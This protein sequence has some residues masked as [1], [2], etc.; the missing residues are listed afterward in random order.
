M[1]VERGQEAP[2]LDP[3]A[4]QRTEL[5]GQLAGAQLALEAVI[6]ELSRNG[7]D[8]AIL[9]ELRN[10][11]VSVIDLRQHVGSANSSDLASLRREVANVTAASHS[12]TQHAVS[13]GSAGVSHPTM[14]HQQARAAIQSVS[15][16]LFDRRVLDPYLQFAS[17]EDEKAYRKREQENAEALKRALALNTPEGD[18]RAVEITRS[19]LADAKAHGADRS[20]DFAQLSG[21]ADAAQAALVAAKPTTELGANSTKIRVADPA[22]AAPTERDISDVASILCA[23]GITNSTNQAQCAGHGLTARST[24][25]AARSASATPG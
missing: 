19:Q 22:A 16:D 10:Q 11:I 2:P 20:P 14:T 7:A 13:S 5:I 8:A 21:E 1:T 9:A 3:L 15:H 12:L 17:E 6:A 23:S 24:T 4:S 18:R 25:N